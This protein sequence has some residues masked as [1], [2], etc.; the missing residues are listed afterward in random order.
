VKKIILGEIEVD[1]ASPVPVY[2]Q[3]KKQNSV[4]KLKKI[5]WVLSNKV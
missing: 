1:F 5:R 4:K 2:L 3:T